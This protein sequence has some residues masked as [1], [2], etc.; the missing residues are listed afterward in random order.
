MLQRLT[1][2]VQH[3]VFGA[4]H[5][6]EMVFV[7]DLQMDHTA[8]G[9]TQA[10]WDDDIVVQCKRYGFPVNGAFEQIQYDCWPDGRRVKTWQKQT[11]ASRSKTWYYW[12]DQ[13]EK[14]L[15][16]LSQERAAQTQVRS[17][18]FDEAQ[19]L[20]QH[21][22]TTGRAGFVCTVAKQFDNYRSVWKYD[23]HIDG[24]IT[25]T[26]PYGN[27][28]HATFSSFDEFVNDLN[29][30]YHVNDFHITMA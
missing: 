7:P 18:T 13:V 9:F 1:Q 11:N 15:H 23:V 8:W 30:Y 16:K 6:Y 3:G 14:H 27:K 24:T 19:A 4:W 22:L 2:A 10:A 28:A 20:A 12:S 17:A 26:R 21:L 5:D 29:R 25:S